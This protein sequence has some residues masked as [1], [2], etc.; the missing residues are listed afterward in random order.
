[1]RFENLT[2]VIPDKADVE[3]DRIADVWI[4]G[5]GTVERLARFWA[6]PPIAKETVRIYGPDTFALVV[7]QKLGVELISPADDLLRK[8]PGPILRR[9][10]VVAA[11]KDA[12]TFPAFV[13]PL[14]PKTFR[15]KI[16]E[17]KEALDAECAGLSP[18]TLVFISEIVDIEGEARF[19]A[20]DGRIETGALYEGTGDLVEAARAA[21]EIAH[22]LPIPKTCVLDL[23]LIRDRGWALLEF[24]ASWGA[25]LNG[26]DPR[27]VAPCIAA[28]T[29]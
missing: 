4:E 25:G 13:K 6:P 21:A 28:A 1:M 23:A 27:K 5:G 3:R 20:L 17:T 8:A 18:E 29:R 15:A 10:V 22:A 12:R 26:C 9:D 16:Y 11:L 2:L 24:N 7:A 14:V 19:F